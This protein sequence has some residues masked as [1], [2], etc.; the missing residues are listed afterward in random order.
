[1]KKLTLIL[2]IADFL[3]SGACLTLFVWYIQDH[4]MAHAVWFL[5]LS[6]IDFGF[7]ILNLQTF[8]ERD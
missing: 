6:I 7:G 8:L 2:A 3:L 1:M 5:I 4:T